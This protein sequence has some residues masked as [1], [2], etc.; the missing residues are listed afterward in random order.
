[1][2]FIFGPFCLITSA[3]VRMF[4]VPSVGMTMY[5]IFLP[6]L[7]TAL[8]KT[9]LIMLYVY[10]WFMLKVFYLCWSGKMHQSFYFLYLY[11]VLY[12]NAIFFY[13]KIKYSDKKK[14]LQQVA[15]MQQRTYIYLVN[16]QIICIYLQ[17]GK[18][19]YVQCIN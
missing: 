1:M 4:S 2:D 7:L 11:C 18:V 5:F 16:Y 13:Y 17:P 19:L 10:F 8:E 15:V 3:C 6:C 14:V 9:F 12:K